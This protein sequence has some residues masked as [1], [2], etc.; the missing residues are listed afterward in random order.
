[1]VTSIIMQT[2]EDDGLVYGGGS[3]NAEKWSSSGCILQDKTTGFAYLY[4]IGCVREDS[5]WLM[6]FLAWA[7]GN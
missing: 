7:T 4:D 6:G 1:M 2:S 3:R 5:G